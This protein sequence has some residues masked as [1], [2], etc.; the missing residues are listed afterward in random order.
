MLISPT[1]SWIRWCMQVYV[2]ELMGTCLDLAERS[3][4]DS[5]RLSSHRFNSTTGEQKGITQTIYTASEPPSRL[6]N[7]LMPSDKLRS[8]N[9]PVFT[10]WCD[11]VGDQTPA[12]RTLSGRSNHYATQ[13]RSFFCGD[14]L[15]FMLSICLL[16]RTF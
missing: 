7:S 15:S 3:M 14:H 5:F 13:E 2:S 4:P 1:A 6:S 12:S 10:Y 11:A 16:C 8:G 9:L